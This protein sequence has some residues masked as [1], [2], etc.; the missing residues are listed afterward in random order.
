[1]KFLS[2]FGSLLLL[3]VLFFQSLLLHAEPAA[4]LITNLA[5]ARALRAD[6]VVSN[7]PP[8][9]IANNRAVTVAAFPCPIVDTDNAK[10][11]GRS[12]GTAPDNAKQ[13][14]V[15]DR[16]QKT[17]SEALAGPSAQR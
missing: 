5:V 13:R 4:R 11:L 7:P 10:G 2:K 14:V 12:R 3:G 9:E 6:Q 1:M 16:Q 17:A 8:F 15:A